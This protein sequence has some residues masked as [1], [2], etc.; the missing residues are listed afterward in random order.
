MSER[1]CGRDLA[2][3]GGGLEETV[4]DNWSGTGIRFHYISSELSLGL[5]AVRDL[6]SA[7]LDSTGPV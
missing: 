4:I 6:T 2:S 1:S 3:A 7:L 5:E